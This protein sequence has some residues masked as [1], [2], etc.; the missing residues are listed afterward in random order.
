[1]N[2]RSFLFLTILFAAVMVIVS[3]E[4]I[5]EAVEPTVTV[6]ILVDRFN[7]DASLVFNLE[8]RGVERRDQAGLFYLYGMAGERFDPDRFESQWRPNYGR[9]IEFE[10]IAWQLGVPPVIFPDEVFQWRRPYHERDFNRKGRW[11]EETVK[12]GKDK[13]E[14]TYE[15]RPNDIKEK[16]RITR[17]KYEFA[18]ES[19][20]EEE[21]LTVDLKKMTYKYKY[22]NTRTN[23]KIERSGTV[24]PM[25]A[26]NIRRYY[27]PQ[28]IDE[29]PK[30]GIQLK[31]EWSFNQ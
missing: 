27:L 15:D 24:L 17:D 23:E 7:V 12:Q 10:E 2:K 4:G 28:F 30:K 20:H 25:T 11:P 18:Y 31:F 1:M 26:E 5:S 6:E 29:K 8:K 16:I 9:D 13:Y 3:V 21:K 22:K 14:Y 19:R